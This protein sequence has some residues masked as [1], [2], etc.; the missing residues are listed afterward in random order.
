[1]N[2]WV[3]NEVVGQRI[4]TPLVICSVHQFSTLFVG[5]DYGFGLIGLVG[6]FA[7]FN[8]LFSLL[9]S[10]RKACTQSFRF[11]LSGLLNCIYY[12]LGLREA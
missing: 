6:W 2:V 3:L 9:T 7:V 11:T 12:Y 8:Q 10:N 4:H 5:L 1:V